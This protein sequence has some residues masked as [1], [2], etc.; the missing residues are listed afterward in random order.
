MRKFYEDPNGG[1]D[2]D[3]ILSSFSEG[4]FI[5]CGYDFSAASIFFT[6]NGRRLS[7]AFGGVYVPRTKYDVYA[8]IGVEGQCHFEVN[9]GGEPFKWK[10]TNEWAWRIEGH[11]GRLSASSSRASHI[12]D[13]LPTYDEAR[14]Q[15]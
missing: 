10:E 4:D 5:G 7:D 11:V 2:Y 1:R 13:E 3:P 8:A 6:Y 15:R 9:F 14:R 12:E